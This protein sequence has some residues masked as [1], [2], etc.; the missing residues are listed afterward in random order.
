MEEIVIDAAL[1]LNSLATSASKTREKKFA[2][3]YFLFIN[4]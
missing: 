1:A 3:Y 4:Y 2:I